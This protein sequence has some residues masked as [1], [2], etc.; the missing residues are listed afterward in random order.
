MICLRNNHLPWCLRTLLFA[1]LFVPFLAENKDVD[2]CASLTCVSLQHNLKG[3]GGCSTS[4]WCLE[5]HSRHPWCWLGFTKDK[6]RQA[7]EL[8]SALAQHG[9]DSAS[10]LLLRPAI[11]G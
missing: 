11:G 1:R 7:Q 6:H 9:T 10:D 5:D 4:C 3:A 8:V 2:P